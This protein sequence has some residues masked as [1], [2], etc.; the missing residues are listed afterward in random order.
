MHISQTN[1]THKEAVLAE[2]IFSNK[3]YFNFILALECTQI[4]RWT[5]PFRNWTL[6]SQ[7]LRPQHSV[8][9]RNRLKNPSACSSFCG[10]VN[11]FLGR[12]YRIW[13]P[14]DPNSFHMLIFLKCQRTGFWVCNIK[15]FLGHSRRLLGWQ[16]ALL[17]FSIPTKTPGRTLW[18]PFNCLYPPE[19]KIMVNDLRFPET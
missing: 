15:N 6:D 18:S 5:N 2:A 16:P 4:L 10:E 1:R 11:A 13:P 19:Q 7:H 8:T 17:A 14:I 9:T 12:Y 3:T